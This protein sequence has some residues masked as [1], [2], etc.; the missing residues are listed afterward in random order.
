MSKFKWIDLDRDDWFHIF[1]NIIEDNIKWKSPFYKQ[2]LIMLGGF[3]S[4]HVPL[5]GMTTIVTYA[6]TMLIRQY[7]L[8][9]TK[10]DF[11]AMKEFEIQFAEEHATYKLDQVLQVWQ[12]PMVFFNEKF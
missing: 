5:I 11:S 4:Q 3:G 2:R 8:Q 6:P 12:N 1:N 9:Q 10:P 7:E